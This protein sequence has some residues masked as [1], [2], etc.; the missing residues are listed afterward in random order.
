M[1][2]QA[3]PWAYNPPPLAAPVG[4]PNPWA[5]NPAVPVPAMAPVP[6]PPMPQAPGLPQ[7]PS[8]AVS[9]NSGAAVPA[10]AAG[11]TAP[12]QA[13]VPTPTPVTNPF[14]VAAGNPIAGRFPGDRGPFFGAFDAVFGAPAALRGQM[15]QLEQQGIERNASGS[16][17]RKV[18][19]LVQAGLAPNKIMAQLMNDPE[20]VDAFTR[21]GSPQEVQSMVMGLITA[22]QP[23]KPTFH[24][25]PAGGMG[26]N[27]DPDTGTMT[28][29]ARAPTDA[30][31]RAAAIQQFIQGQQQPGTQS[32]T[33]P[34]LDAARAAG[35]IP[36]LAEFVHNTIG[37][38][39]PNMIDETLLR[40]RVQLGILQEN[41][42][43][44]FRR[45]GRTALQEQARILEIP[46]FK[47]ALTTPTRALVAM[48]VIRQHTE[49]QIGSD[50]QLLSNP[51]TP[52]KVYNEAYER[53]HMGRNL[54][55]RLGTRE[56]IQAAMEKARQAK[57]VSDAQ[58]QLNKVTG[59]PHVEVMK[60]PIVRE[61]MRVFKDGGLDAQVPDAL[62][63]QLT[64][65]QQRAVIQEL[66][67]QSG[68][69]K[70]DKSYKGPAQVP[71]HK[72]RPEPGPQIPGQS[73]GTTPSE[74]LR[75]RF[76]KPLAREYS[77]F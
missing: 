62:W 15:M 61:V 24:A 16:L 10:A 26:F 7:H 50:L 4:Q 75:G 48:D 38:I 53:V 30:D 58:G 77:Q 72:G 19:P 18:A 23:P 27:R 25:L 3:N 36:T 59:R 44:F 63:K 12:Q 74:S 14:A 45:T 9:P 13:M 52:E 5:Y 69:T 39:N 8:A 33:T 67:D 29:A 51:A 31:V 20:F 56:Q 40:D 32:G 11:T 43:D 73:G 66:K 37:Q 21:A 17:V 2:N 68:D 41:V 65:E 46:R 6:I 49:D 35:A 42:L 34:A 57:P 71:A 64:S 47:S 70:K 54:L 22:A 60:D 28:P 55:A 76:H 1:A